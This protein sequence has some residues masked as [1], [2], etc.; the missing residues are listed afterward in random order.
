MYLLHFLSIDFL[1]IVFKRVISSFDFNQ[2]NGF[3]LLVGIDIF[4]VLVTI[5]VAFLAF[6]F[7][8]QPMI[9]VG[10]NVSKRIYLVNST[11]EAVRKCST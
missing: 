2:I 11:P 9:N 8:E 7:I 10:R 5:P 6:K 4:V 3:V 1:R